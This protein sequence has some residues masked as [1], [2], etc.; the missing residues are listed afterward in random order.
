[1]KPPA[2]RWVFD[3]YFE[4]PIFWG[5]DGA[6]NEAD[7]LTK[8]LQGRTDFTMTYLNKSDI[9]FPRGRVMPLL[10]GTS[11]T[12]LPRD[13]AKG[14]KHLLL[15]MVSN[16]SPTR[17]TVMEELMALLPSGAVHVFGECGAPS[18]CPGRN[19][20]DECYQDLFSKYKFYAAFENSR[21][22]GYITEKFY[23]GLQQGMVPVA[24]GGLSRRD[25]ERVAPADSFLHVDDFKSTRELA[26]RLVEIDNNDNL[27]NSMFA[28]RQRFTMQLDREVAEDAY[29]EL[30]KKVHADTAP[31]NY[32]DLAS[33]WYDGTCSGP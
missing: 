27:Y 8:S 30:C 13:F 18:P 17:M 3:A 4:P 5:P 25:Y 21:C 24:R 26:D 7:Y 1:M 10:D 12:S 29:C 11:T 14:R 15:W 31:Q 6:V 32:D 9:F 22:E 2:Q 28:W 16:C 19:D 23:R 33:W 20:I